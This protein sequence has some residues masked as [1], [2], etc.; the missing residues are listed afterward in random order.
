LEYTGIDGRILLRRIFRKR[1]VGYGLDLA[2]LGLV[3]SCGHL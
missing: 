3:T 1:D 2:D